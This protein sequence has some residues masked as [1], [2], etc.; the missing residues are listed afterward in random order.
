MQG[1]FAWNATAKKLAR[2]QANDRPPSKTKPLATRSSHDTKRQ[3]V[4][5]FGDYATMIS[6]ILS[7]NERHR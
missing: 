7:I 5:I 4:A 2:Q 6:F 3:Q 1:A